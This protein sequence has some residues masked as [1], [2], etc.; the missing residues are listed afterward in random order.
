MDECG[1][2]EALRDRVEPLEAHDFFIKA[3]SFL[4]AKH[5]WLVVC[6]CR[7]GGLIRARSERYASLRV[8]SSLG[9]A[10]ALAGNCLNGVLVSGL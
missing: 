4:T 10:I 1:A 2:L 9:D 7:C 8:G 5:G 6:R 3:E